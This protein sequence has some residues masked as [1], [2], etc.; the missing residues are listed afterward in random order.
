MIVGVA[1][2]NIN[3]MCVVINETITLLFN[4]R[5]PKLLFTNK[6]HANVGKRVYEV[7]VALPKEVHPEHS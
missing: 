6:A 7:R 5:N 1:L 2:V 3:S 4:I